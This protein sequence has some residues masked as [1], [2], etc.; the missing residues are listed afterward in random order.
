MGIVISRSTGVALSPFGNVP[1]EVPPTSSQA[2]PGGRERPEAAGPVAVPTPPEQFD[3]WEIELHGRRVVY[4]VA[5]S[6]PPVVLIHGML[7]SSSH[8]E[9]VARSLALDHTVLAPDLVGHG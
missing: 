9:S 4:R 1:R 8:W 7:N 6:G 3:E 5:G 2:G